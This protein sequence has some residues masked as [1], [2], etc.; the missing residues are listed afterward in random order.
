MKKKIIFLALSLC[1]GFGPAVFAQGISQTASSPLKTTT[2]LQT[3]TQPLSERQLQGIVAAL[4]SYHDIDA[5]FSEA[6]RLAGLGTSGA[7]MAALSGTPK[8]TLS[9]QND[10]D[11]RDPATAPR[12]QP[13]GPELAGNQSDSGFRYLDVAPPGDVSDNPLIGLGYDFAEDGSGQDLNRRDY[14]ASQVVLPGT[15]TDADDSDR[16]GTLNNTG[17]LMAA[18]DFSSSPESRLFSLPTD[19]SLDAQH[20][21][22][23]LVT[24]IEADR[25]ILVLNALELSPEDFKHE[26]VPSGQLIRLGQRSFTTSAGFL[27]PLNSDDGS[28]YNLF[29]THFMGSNGAREVLLT[30]EVGSPNGAGLDMLLSD[31]SEA[32]SGMAYRA[33]E[34]LA[35]GGVRL[36]T[37]VIDDISGGGVLE[38]LE[39]RLLDAKGQGQGLG[40]FQMRSEQGIVATGTLRTI[41]GTDGSL[42][43]YLDLDQ[44]PALVI[45][46]DASG[47]TRMAWLTSDISSAASG[48]NIDWKSLNIS[49]FSSELRKV[50]D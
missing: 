7:P 48:D 44:G 18:L 2:Q 13:Q 46:E 16:L 35:D 23:Q 24:R 31:R 12:P 40:L 4:A 15:V 34:A 37:S 39:E 38:I 43:T 25:G 1:I 29:S 11:D 26:Q 32:L 9:G 10:A 17:V 20:F 28:R 47:K 33:S 8:G 50:F 3:Q 41:S 19:G 36:T 21:A 45:Q 5:S 27:D 42:L 30:S 6:V 22:D 14:S 49:S